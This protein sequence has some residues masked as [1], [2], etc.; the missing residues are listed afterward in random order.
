VDHRVYPDLI[1][2]DPS[3]SSSVA[4]LLVVEAKNHDGGR[5]LAR[6]RLRHQEDNANLTERGW[7]T[8]K[9]LGFLNEL[10]YQYAAYVELVPGVPSWKWVKQ[11]DLDDIERPAAPMW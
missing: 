10:G 3:T 5:R 6:R 1:V 11:D 8:K 4:N 2:H 9:L 7:D